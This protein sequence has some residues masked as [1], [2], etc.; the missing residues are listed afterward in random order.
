[1]DNPRFQT[2][3]KS[4]Q[5]RLQ[6]MVDSLRS[7]I[8]YG[9]Y[10]PGQLLPSELLLTEQYGLSNKSVRKGLDILVSEGLIVKVDRVGSRVTDNIPVAPVSVSF[11]YSSSIERDFSLSA[12]L[13]DFH[14]L[15]RSIRI[16]AMPLRSTVDYIKAVEEYMDNGLLDT[17][18]LNN[19][20]FQQLLEDGYAQSLN[21]MG[22]E[23]QSYRFA[24]EAFVDEQQLLAKPVVFSPLVLAYNRSHFQENHVPEP[25]GSWTW[26]DVV[27]HASALAVP[28]VRHGLYF[29]L[30]SDNRWP[31]FLLQSCM[32]FEPSVNGTFQLDGSRLM[33][34]I[35]LCKR[36]ITSHDLF[37]R[38]LSENSDDVNE[39]F[40]QGKVSMILAN[41]M[42]I[43][44]FKEMNIDYDLSPIP[45]MYEPRSLLN[46]IGIAI[47]RNSKQLQASKCFADYLTSPRA[48]SILRNRSLSLPALKSAAEAPL[49]SGDSL[50]RP[51]RFFLF[52][53][54]MFS[55]RTHQELNLPMSS[56]YALKNLLKQYW[57]DLIDEQTLCDHMERLI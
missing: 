3:R 49:E 43:N 41:Y 27:K 2:G 9:V 54:I 21:P 1:M 4:F 57:S 23:A 53:E 52:R 39:L 17:F 26:E 34:S 8:L 45:F 51:A 24:Q 31:A 44:D 55:Y 13:D 22:P 20:D 15:H 30:L 42:A 7:D 48:Q 36:L 37:P 11:G 32:R 28:G 16:K 12:L 19:L 33:E 47:N 50:N 38:Y 29:Y 14:S 35:R 18:T 10:P 25:D 56:F 5:L 6:H 40:A 46:V